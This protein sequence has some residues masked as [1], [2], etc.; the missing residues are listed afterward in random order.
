MN[1]THQFLIVPVVKLREANQA[2]K[3]MMISSSH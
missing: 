1:R 2:D 3:R